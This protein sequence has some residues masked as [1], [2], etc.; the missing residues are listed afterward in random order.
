MGIDHALINKLKPQ[1]QSASRIFHNNTA[2]VLDILEMISKNPEIILEEFWKLQARAKRQG[3]PRP[4][5]R[6]ATW[7]RHTVFLRKVE[8]LINPS[9]L[10]DLNDVNV[11]SP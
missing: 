1:T 4:M 2:R 3:P 6:G 11:Q 8:S 7:A 5:E 10:G 9:L